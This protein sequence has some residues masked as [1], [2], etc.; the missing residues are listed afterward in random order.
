MLLVKII[1][2]KLTC[3]NIYFNNKN[4]TSYMDVKYRDLRAALSW[5]WTWTSKV[6]V[7]YTDL[8]SFL[9]IVY[10]QASLVPMDMDLDLWVCAWV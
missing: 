7:C 8:K 9:G 3:L 4:L 1:G 10:F 5:E 2:S 6:L